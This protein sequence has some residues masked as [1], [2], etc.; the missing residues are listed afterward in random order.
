MPASTTLSS[1]LPTLRRGVPV[2]EIR[3]LAVEVAADPTKIEALISLLLQSDSHDKVRLQK[4]AWVLNHAFQSD[5]RAFFAFRGPLGDVLDAVDDPSALRELL[6]MLASPVWV[7]L[8][9]ETQRRDILDLGLGLLHVNDL[10]LALHYA[11]MQLVQSR[12]LSEEDYAEGL[13]GL[14][15]LRI[16]NGE[17]NPPL[18][19][20]ILRYEAKFLK[21]LNRLREAD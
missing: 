21:R 14:R 9:K 10:P 7:D 13:D 8:E 15:A 2:A 20:C 18:K 17:D 6:K 12:A 16:S 3:S 4:A 11:A 5:E 1:L 19:R